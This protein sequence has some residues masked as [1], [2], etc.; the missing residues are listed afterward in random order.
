MTTENG[1]SGSIRVQWSDRTAP[2]SRIEGPSPLGRQAQPWPR[3]VRGVGVGHDEV[4]AIAAVSTAVGDDIAGLEA[5]VRR[6]HAQQAAAPTTVDAGDLCG[7]RH[8][9]RA[10]VPERHHLR[11]VACLYAV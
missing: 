9:V 2:R 1:P 7:H 5:P 4:P 3:S 6:R 11:S 8:V 10:A